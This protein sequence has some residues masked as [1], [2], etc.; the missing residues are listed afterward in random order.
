MGK[1]YRT[2]SLAAFSKGG[3]FALGAFRIY[4]E[5]KLNQ[6]SFANLPKRPSSIKGQ[7]IRRAPLPV[8]VQNASKCIKKQT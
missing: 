4:Y 6:G 3:D 5:Q 1:L 7:T 8:F 2:F